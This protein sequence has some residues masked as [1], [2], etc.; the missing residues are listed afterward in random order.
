MME[1]EANPDYCRGK[2]KFDAAL[3]NFRNSGWWLERYFGKDPP[4]G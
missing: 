4:I 3:Q 2:P 1:F